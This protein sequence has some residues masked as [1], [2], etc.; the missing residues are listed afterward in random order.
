MTFKPGTLGLDFVASVS[1]QD[2]IV[3]LLMENVAT[4]SGQS[5]SIA[6]M[7]L[8]AANS[9]IQS[10]VP[11][12]FEWVAEYN[13]YY[14]A[15]TRYFFDMNTNLFY[16][17]DTQTYY[18]YDEATQS[19][20]VYAN[21]QQKQW[22]RA[23]YR[24]RAAELLGE[25][26]IQRYDQEAVDICEFVF[27]IVDK[28]ADLEWDRELEQRKSAR[29]QRD[30]SRD[31]SRDRD[32]E[33]DRERDR[34]RRNEEDRRREERRREEEEDR[35]E[36]KK[37][38]EQEERERRERIFNELEDTDLQAKRSKKAKRAYFDGDDVRVS[39]EEEEAPRRSNKK[40]KS[41]KEAREDRHR[42]RSRSRHRGGTRSRSRD[43]DR[44]RDRSRERS[45]RERSRDRSR[46][47]SWER[48]RI[49]DRE[50]DRV[51]DERRRRDQRDSDS[52]KTY[53]S[54]GSSDGGF[55]EN[56]PNPEEM[57][58][59]QLMEGEGFT[60]A[61]CLRIID[62]MGQLNIVTITG[63]LIGSHAS[64]AIRSDSL[65]EYHSEIYYVNTADET[66]GP[67]YK[68][69][70]MPGCTASLDGQVLEEND[71]F[72]LEH[73]SWFIAGEVVLIIHV[74]YGYNSCPRCDP[75]QMPKPMA[76]SEEAERVAKGAPKL[77][78]A[79]VRKRVLN[80]MKKQYGIMEGEQNET[81]YT[82][83]AA[84]RRR[85]VGSTYPV[86][87]QR[88]RAQASDPNDIYANCSAR[89]VPGAA[90]FTAPKT[91][92]TPIEAE[93]KGFKLL[94]MMGWTE[95]K[96]LGKEQSGRAEPVAV[97]QKSDRAGLG[98]AQREAPK[99]L[100]QQIFDATRK[101]FEEITENEQK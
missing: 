94:K 43:R 23:R 35:R 28:V 88:Q 64:S 17:S 3:L 52:V 91:V 55:Q 37:R 4:T 98:T 77:S 34:Q 25:G 70:V 93:N 6:E 62:Q 21:M 15:A 101:R 27:N 67:G 12:G 53:S 65:A 81:K 7:L 75:G 47:R 46:D 96:G 74:H 57:A 44:R 18:Y 16:H 19:Y 38:K 10:S 72:D 33:R 51:S 48:R 71:E 5:S 79:A 42:D 69:R 78:K 85:N 20:C 39:S 61:P 86:N 2:D 59:Q 89:P 97:L 29:R 95:G 40:K 31:R 82:D 50:R 8:E 73:G 66:R 76:M 41:K 49:R 99:S 83:R 11:D 9:V 36:R 84:N 90:P 30:R 68:L 87:I 14:S 58:W 80:A 45:H 63:G 22:D 60:E 100:K 24:R 32:R 26:E 1:R 56:M 13:M 54:N 92:N